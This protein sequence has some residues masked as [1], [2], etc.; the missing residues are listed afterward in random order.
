M[1]NLNLL[2][3]ASTETCDP[4]FARQATEHAHTA[5]ARIVRS[6]GST[7]HVADF[8]S[9]TGAFLKQDTHQGLSATSCWS[10]GQSW[11]VYGFAQCYRNTGDFAFL[12]AARNLA[13][14][15]LHRLPP[16]QV[17][18]W[19]YDANDV[20]DSSAAAILASGLLRLAAAESDKALA[21]CWRNEAMRIISSL[22]QN[23][24][25]RGT[26]EPSILIHGTRNKPRGSMDHGLIYGDYYFV[27]ALT[28]LEGAK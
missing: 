24:T 21:T 10:R 12:S 27:E 28:M 16:D 14:F 11:A 19:D 9:D 4:L 17:P 3:W 13:I 7:A 23:Y 1:M 25:G 2:Y 20:R 26:D 8:D 22:W 5:L 18:Y 6:D 15:A